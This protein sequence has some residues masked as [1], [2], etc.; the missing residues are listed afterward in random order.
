[1]TVTDELKAV[2]RPVPN[3]KTQYTLFL[4]WAS[5][6]SAPVNVAAAFHL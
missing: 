4:P 3:W 6:T 5:R 1:M 2:V